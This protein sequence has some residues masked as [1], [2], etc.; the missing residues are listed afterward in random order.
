MGKNS[1]WLYFEIA[2]LNC[3]YKSR[4]D[5]AVTDQIKSNTFALP[6]KKTYR[7][8]SF[9]KASTSLTYHPLTLPC[10]VKLL[11]EYQEVDDIRHVMVS[12]VT[13]KH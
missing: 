1:A 12:M 7:E 4:F 9:L 11:T 10:I 8:W 5:Y 6:F 3:F 2:W 13:R